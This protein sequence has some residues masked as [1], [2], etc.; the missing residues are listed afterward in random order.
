MLL[1]VCSVSEAE[2]PT[3]ICLKQALPHAAGECSRHRRVGDAAF[4]QIIRCYVAPRRS[5]EYCNM[6]VCLSVRLSARITRKPHGQTSPNF[7]ACCLYGR[8]SVL[9][10]RRSDTL[11][12][13][14][15]VDDVIFSYHGASGPYSS[16]TLCLEE[17]RQVA[18]SVGRQDDCY[19]SSSGSECGAAGRGGESAIY[20]CL[21]VVVSERLQR[22]VS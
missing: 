11:C 15:C 3:C 18:V 6:Y 10:R 7:C 9:L 22:T 20:D 17:V 4:Y 5:A 2:Q 1:C 12:T 13:S 19:V 8:D 16:T 14:G 21:V